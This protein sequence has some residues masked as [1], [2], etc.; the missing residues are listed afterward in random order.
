MRF[1]FSNCK[2]L[3]SE[4]EEAILTIGK[5]GWGKSTFLNYLNGA[6]LRVT[7]KGGLRVN[8]NDKEITRIGSGEGSTTLFP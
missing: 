6:D 5:T 7:T 1:I 8:E 4:V 2:M 3:Q